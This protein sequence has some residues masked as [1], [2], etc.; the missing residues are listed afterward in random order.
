[1]LP[2]AIWQSVDFK[3]LWVYHGRVAVTERWSEEITVPAGWFW[4]ECGEGRIRVGDREI[5]VNAGQSFYTAPGTRRQWFAAGT[6]L[7]SVGFRCDW[8]CGTPVFQAGLNIT[9]SAARS[10]LL[11]EQTQKLFR[12]VHDSEVEVSYQDGIVVN[13]YDFAEWC[14][15]ESAFRNWFV[16]YVET[17]YQQG[18]EPQSLTTSQDRRVEGLVLAL[19]EWPLDETLNLSKLGQGS[20]LG[21]RRVHDLLRAHLGMTAQAWLDE[22]RLQLARERLFS[23]DTALKE[24][25]FHL[26]FKH[27]PHFTA[28]FKRHTGMTPTAF[29]TGQGVE[30]A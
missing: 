3:W 5:S 17:L 26:G 14:G 7:L 22:R 4:V 1:M 28:W 15:R 19:H 30:G 11:L 21:S 9:N 12:S 18:I 10:R 29:R 2:P 27:P 23:E 16:I 24:I 13:S 25:A 6:R 8:P 20:R